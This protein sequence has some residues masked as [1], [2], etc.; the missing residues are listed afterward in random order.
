MVLDCCLHMKG[1][2]T[3]TELLICVGLIR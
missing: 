1:T 3:G 2:N